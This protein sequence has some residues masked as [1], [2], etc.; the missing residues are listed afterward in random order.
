MVEGAEGFSFS[1]LPFP[2]SRRF[3]Q[4]A[5]DAPEK[6]FGEGNQNSE[7]GKEVFVACVSFGCPTAIV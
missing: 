3:R 1:L 7:P 2:P 5:S 6:S 4:N